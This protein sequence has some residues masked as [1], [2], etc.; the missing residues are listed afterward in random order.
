MIKPAL[1]L[2]AISLAA[3][4]SSDAFAHSREWYAA[5]LPEAKAT[6][7]RC[8]ARLKTEGTLPKEDM[9]EC[10]RA[11]TAIVHTTTF[12]PSKSVSY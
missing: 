3:V 4:S 7:E 5:N 1:L 9:D 6:N 8:L 12:T 10:Q 2:I 11:S